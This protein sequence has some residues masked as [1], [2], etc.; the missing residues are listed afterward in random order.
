[1]KKALVLSGGGSRGS[2]QAGVI[3]H[4]L[5]E[6]CERYDIISGT[7]VGALNGAFL[8]QYPHGKE[9]EAAEDLKR[10][11]FSISDAKVWKH[12]G[13]R[14]MATLW[15]HS[16]YRTS[17]LRR[18]VEEHLDPKK[19]RASGKLLRVGAVS[20]TTG[21]RRIWTEQ[22][23]DI[24]DGVMASSSFPVFFEPIKSRGHWYTDDGVRE[25]APGHAAILAGADEIHAILCSKPGLGEW[26]PG[27]RITAL[28]VAQRSIGIMS[29][30]ILANDL[31]RIEDISELARL[32]SP[33][34][35]EKREIAIHR[36][37]PSRALDLKSSLDFRVEKARKNWQLGLE[38]ARKA[39]WS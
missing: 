1:M 22:D 31:S 17:P 30:E 15:K 36:V 6:R 18:L 25:Q 34:A 32:G 5:H 9:R 23:A 20:L 7:S 12:W 13:M 38:D 28:E 10:M 16:V 33:R 14:R 39:R 24:R 11:W 19:I 3:Y 29:D 35:G 2:Y 4:L 21:K 27:E 37:E 8:A 26:D